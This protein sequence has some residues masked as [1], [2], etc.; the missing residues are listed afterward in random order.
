MKKLNDFTEDECIH[1]KNEKDFI[2]ILNNF[3]IPFNERLRSCWGIHSYNTVLYPRGMFGHYQ[4]AVDRKERI[5]SFFEVEELKELWE[6]AYIVEEG[7]NLL[8]F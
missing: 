5:Y 3:S 7:K 2:F 6:N 4:F 8:A 1:C